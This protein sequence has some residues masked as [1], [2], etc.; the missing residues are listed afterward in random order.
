MNTMSSTMNDL[1]KRGYVEDFR[2]EK[3]GLQHT[4][5]KLQIRPEEFV[6][7]EVYGYEGMPNPEDEGV[8]YAITSAKYHLKGILR[9]TGQWIWDIL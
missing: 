5:S 2:L 9:N 4:D 1:R 6:I 8:L 3:L 7:D